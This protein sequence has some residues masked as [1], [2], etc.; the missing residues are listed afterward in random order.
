MRCGGNCRG[1]RR[2]IAHD[3]KGDRR[4]DNHG[5]KDDDAQN[6]ASG[7]SASEGQRE[8]REGGKRGTLPEKVQEG[9]AEGPQKVRR[10]PLSEMDHRSFLS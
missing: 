6:I 10:N 2:L 7:R 1:L 8:S 3:E 5:R 4:R 9:Q